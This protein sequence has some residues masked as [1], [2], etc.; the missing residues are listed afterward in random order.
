MSMI[1]KAVQVMNTITRLR[2]TQPGTYLSGSAG[3]PILSFQ[4]TRY[5]DIT[6]LEDRLKIHPGKDGQLAT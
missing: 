4:I 3:W 5:A 1:R 2:Y 6:G